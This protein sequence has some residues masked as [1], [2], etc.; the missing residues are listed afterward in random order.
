M[1][2]K[3]L[4]AELGIADSTFR[5]WR[6]AL[7]VPAKA[8]YTDEEVIKFKKL[9][10]KT[11]NG[12]KFEDAVADLNGGKKRSDS[13][14][15]VNALTKHYQPMIEQVSDGIADNLVQALDAAVFKSFAKKLKGTAADIEQLEQSLSLDNSEIIDALLLEGVD[16]ECA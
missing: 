4:I 13:N 14:P 5:K 1:N 9:K 3:E 8:T 6:L 12:E 7:G 11:E 16:D 10:A 2:Q 15:L